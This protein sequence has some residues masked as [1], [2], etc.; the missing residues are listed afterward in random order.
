M[1]EMRQSRQK[2]LYTFPNGY[3][4]TMSMAKMDGGDSKQQKGKKRKEAEKGRKKVRRREVH[5]WVRIT[6]REMRWFFKKRERG[7]ADADG[8]LVMRIRGL[9]AG[10]RLMWLVFQTGGKRYPQGGTGGL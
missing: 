3:I 5:I 8:R 1:V 6:V 2:K 9:N 4:S 10:T 7:K